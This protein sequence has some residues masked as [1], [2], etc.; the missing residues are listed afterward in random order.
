MALP[1]LKTKP[2]PPERIVKSASELHRF[3]AD[4][5][6]SIE[7]GGTEWVR[8][9]ARTKDE[10]ARRAGNPKI[11]QIGI[12]GTIGKNAVSFK[13]FK[14]GSIEQAHSSVKITYLGKEL[15]DLA[16]KVQPLLQKIIEETYPD[17][18]T[19]RLARDWEWRVQFRATPGGKGR[20]SVPVGKKLPA[21]IGLYDVLW[22]MPMGPVPTEYAWFANYYSKKRFGYK[23]NI[24]RKT[25]H[26]INATT[27]L[28]EKKKVSRL[29]KRMVGFAGETSRRMRGAKGPGLHVS[30]MMIQSP[31]LVRGARAKWG[32]PVIRVSFSPTLH[33][34]VQ[35]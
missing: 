8:E 2:V 4:D 33:T 27:G 16:N 24:T 7:K 12:N 26:Q 1:K 20:W 15:A 14:P 22:L 18:K 23:Y 31:L 13:G 9:M 25:I 19:K 11:R 34:A 28:V 17:S 35:P 5:L 21:G 29:K 32:M 30:S 10:E 6:K 3:L